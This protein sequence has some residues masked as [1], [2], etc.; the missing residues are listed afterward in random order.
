MRSKV[1]INWLRNDNNNAKFFQSPSNSR[2][3][4]NR[5][6]TFM[7]DGSEC[8]DLNNIGTEIVN[9]DKQLYSKN[10]QTAAW[11]STLVVKHISPEQTAWLERAVEEENIKVANFSLAAD[12]PPGP[13][14][15]QWRFSKNAGKQLSLI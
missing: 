8:E 2:K 10:A 12:K 14:D 1:P 15:L 3:T 9:Y 7:I 6:L 5:I 4:Q 13:M 11:F